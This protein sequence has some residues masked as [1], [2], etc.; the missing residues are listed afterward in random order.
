MLQIMSSGVR[1]GVNGEKRTLEVGETDN[2]PMHD[3]DRTF[4]DLLVI[5]RDAVPRDVLQRER[6]R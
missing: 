6:I 5:E 3:Y 1:R 4:L 2:I